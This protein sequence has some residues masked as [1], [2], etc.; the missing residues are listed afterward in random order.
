VETGAT[1][2][3]RP[4]DRQGLFG[5]A[6]SGYALD[7]R[8][9]FDGTPR[10]AND[11]HAKTS[12]E[13]RKYLK[14]SEF[15][16]ACHD[17]RLF[18]TDTLRG[19]NGE[20]FKRLRNAYSE[21]VA[22]AEQRARAGKSVPSCQ[23]CHMST[24]P[25]I[26]EVDA[27]SG[28]VGRGSAAVGQRACPPGTSFRPREPGSLGIGQIANVSRPSRLVNH[29]F[30]SVDVPLSPDFDVRLIDDATLDLNGLPLGLEQRRDLLLAASLRLELGELRVR[31]QRLELPVTVENVGAGHRVPAGFSQER[32]IWIELAIR[33]A[34]GQLLYDV[35]RIASDAEDL[36]D[37]TFLR[38]NTSDAAQDAEC[39]PQGLF[40]ADIADG[41]DVPE[42]DPNPD[43]GGALFRGRG[44]INFQNGFLRCVRCIGEIDGRGRC[45]PGPGQGVTR[46]DRYADG[47]Y[48]ID[49]GACRSNLSGREALFETYFPVGALDATRGILKAPDAIIDS[50]S[51]APETP[52]TYVY[53]LNTLGRRGPF[54]AEA[55]LLFRAFPPFL[56]RAFIAYEREQAARGRR[57]TGP[58]IDERVFER[59]SVVE[60][61]RATKQ[62]D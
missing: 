22:Y 55:R 24:F 44:L 8:S 43:L 2:E 41:P 14:S 57:P 28:S 36:R 10:V 18:G 62:G 20:H 46:A 33:D 4:E 7:S 56:L 21:W 9:F 29:Y 49:T 53:E 35:G 34:D 45:R 13:A 11:A 5:I 31:N 48:D 40:G 32:E 38:I 42:W 3:M 39:R 12:V 47:D 15:C 58:L 50:R 1:F 23:H 30:S 27:N 51:L 26:C 16:G 59:L 17:V 19:T 37:K 6:N 25:G 61:A 60:L 52:V 54:T